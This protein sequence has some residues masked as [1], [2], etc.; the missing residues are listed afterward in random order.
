MNLK[1]KIK[2]FIIKKLQHI[3][4]TFHGLGPSKS[5]SRLV[6]GILEQTSVDKELHHL[7]DRLRYG[8]KHKDV[9]GK[10]SHHIRPFF[11]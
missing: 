1:D 7:E 4:K 6:G 3:R 2:K 11:I 10:I 9:Q 8:R 5:F